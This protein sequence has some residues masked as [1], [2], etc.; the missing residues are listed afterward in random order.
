MVVAY[1]KKK[2]YFVVGINYLMTILKEK[3]KETWSGGCIC[4]KKNV[5]I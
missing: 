2:S 4:I 3:K 5:S 1:V